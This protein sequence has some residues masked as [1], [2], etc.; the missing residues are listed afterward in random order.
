MLTVSLLYYRVGAK[1]RY[2][3]IDLICLVRNKDY[4]YEK[5]S[6]GKDNTLV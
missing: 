1:L 5:R 6:T 2:E 3:L 4:Y